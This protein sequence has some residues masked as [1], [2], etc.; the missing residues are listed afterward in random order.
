M[1]RSSLNPKRGKDGSV[2]PLKEPAMVKLRRRFRVGNALYEAHVRGGVPV[3]AGVVLPKD[4]E[5]L[6]PVPEEIVMPE[7]NEADELIAEARREAARIIA[8]AE[9]NIKKMYAEASATNT[10]P[11]GNDENE[12]GGKSTPASGT[13]EL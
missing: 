12:A 3:P 6:G 10:D 8:E 4:A 5:I 2:L 13:V 9:E 11:Q 1:A 7:T